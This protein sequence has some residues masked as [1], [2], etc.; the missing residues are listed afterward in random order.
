MF[1]K[2]SR[3]GAESSSVREQNRVP[4]TKKLVGT[5]GVSSSTANGE[6]NHNE[7]QDL[8]NV[9]AA[10]PSFTYGDYETIIAD[11]AAKPDGID[12]MTYFESFTTESPL[13]VSRDG[14]HLP[15]VPTAGS[16][17]FELFLLEYCKPNHMS[18]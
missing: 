1:R 14:P 6:L 15:Q 11:A 16:S 18:Q 8:D 2:S 7:G 9:R 4:E 3:W 10:S 17:S 12:L 13:I 5:A